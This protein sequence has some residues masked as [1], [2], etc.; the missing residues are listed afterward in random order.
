[1]SLRCVVVGSGVVGVMAALR[2]AERGAG[3]TLVDASVPG[4]GT[5]GTTFA[6]VNASY[7]G[8]WDYFELRAAGVAG[9]RRLR[10]EL[11]SAPW[12]VDTGFLQVERSP[13][14]HGELGRH[15]DRLREA[16]YPVARVRPDACAGWSPI[17]WSRASVEEIF[18][19]PDEGYV[20]VQRDA[21]A[22]AA[23][24]GAS[25]ASACAGTIG[26]WGSRSRVTACAA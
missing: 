22:P 23:R 12:L 7:A 18:F 13:Q 10:A 19:Y 3:V 24:G 25:S 8:Y 5:S 4:S 17:W 26:W 2:L 20:E 11:G 21:R 15:A 16:G 6:H 14:K 1:M 9:Y